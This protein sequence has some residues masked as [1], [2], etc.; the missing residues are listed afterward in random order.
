MPELEA[1]IINPSASREGAEIVDR[2]P[3][4]IRGHHLRIFRDLIMQHYYRSESPADF[5]KRTRLSHAEELKSLIAVKPNDPEIEYYHDLLGQ[6]TES[7]DQ[8]EKYNKEIFE[9]FLHLPSDYPV[10]IVEGMPDVLCA[11]CTVGQ[12]CR[13]LIQK[14]GGNFLAYDGLRLNLFLD[15]LNQLGLPKPTITQEPVFFSDAQ[16]QQARHI[17]TTAETVKKILKKDSFFYLNNIGP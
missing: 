7:A 10:K 11:G 5:A 2:K 6:T 17:K 1:S 13:K 4:V 9:R 3:F 15:D 12:H 8:Y 14:G 16:P